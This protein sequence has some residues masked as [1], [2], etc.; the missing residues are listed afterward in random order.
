MEL[1]E[2]EI[3]E[4]GAGAVGHGQAVAGGQRR[5]GGL[6]PGRSA[7][8]GGEDGGAG[9]HRVDLVA[10]AVGRTAEAAVVTDQ[11]DGEGL[12]DDGDARMGAHGLG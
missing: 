8:T 10:V 12:L 2:F 4:L 1:H 5:V 6:A 11:V 3:G 7:T 9:A